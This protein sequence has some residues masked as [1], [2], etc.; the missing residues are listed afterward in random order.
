MVYAD[1]TG[2]A[3][4]PAAHPPRVVRW[5]DPLL[6]L[7]AARAGGIPLRAWLSW[8]RQCE[9][10]NGLAWRDPLPFFRGRLGPALWRQ[11]AG[12]LSEP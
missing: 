3:R 4:P 7:R 5:C 6:D 8:V 10:I 11:T 12:R 9:A 2:G 1:L